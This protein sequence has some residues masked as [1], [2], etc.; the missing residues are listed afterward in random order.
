MIAR[1]V[2]CKC[3]ERTIVLFEEEPNHFVVIHCI[4]EG[5]VLDQEQDG[6]IRNEKGKI[7]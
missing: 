1:V 5:V 2:K 6:L 4:C 7:K 3:G